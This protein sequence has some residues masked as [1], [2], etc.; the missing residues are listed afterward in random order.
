MR[1]LID[2]IFV[3]FTT[4]I[5]I[6]SLKSIIKNESHSLFNFAILMLYLVQCF[7]V[8]C[9]LLFGYPDY[10]S[11]LSEFERALNNNLVALIYN[12]YISATIFILHFFSR[13]KIKTSEQRESKIQIEN[14][15]SYMIP[16][17]I[18]VF[19]AV[20]P[21]IHILLSG[22]IMYYIIY[23]SAT[24]RGISPE[25]S[26]NN[27]M[28]ILIAI[29]SLMIWYFREKESVLRSI[30]F[31]FLLFLNF[32]A[33]GKRYIVATAFFCFIY[34][35][36][37]RRKSSRKKKIKLFLI[38]A[39]LSCGLIVFSSVYLIGTRGI[40]EGWSNLYA[41]LRI[42]FGRDDV[43]KY[44]ILHE[45]IDNKSIL[46]Y[47]GQ[48]VI[49]TLL[50]II[51]RSIF[52]AKP[53]PHYRYLTAAIYDIPLLEIPS[54]M[55][56]SFLEMSISNFGILGFVIAIA[57][58]TWYCYAADKETNSTKKFLYAIVMLGFMTQ[59]LDSMWPLF[60]LV[61]FFLLTRNVRFTI[62]G[63]GIRF[64]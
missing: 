35:F 45:F 54:G 20:V 15:E 32:W 49:G 16:N 55:T 52:P 53:Y 42:D 36:S 27:M 48:T 30:V 37:T 34:M 8:L 1:I 29:T 14:S 62:R 51:P 19:L 46:E 17:F 4:Y 61:L 25:F 23:G 31:V 11:Y 41:T 60:Y 28:L 13:H 10:A 33:G 56:P 44:T 38:I 43:V 40:S 21:F 58:I 7:P 57:F 26:E 39:V 22:N 12:I 5:M 24:Q 18:L 2:V 59:S 6:K 3:L 64:R 50:M 63:K 47:P 9:D